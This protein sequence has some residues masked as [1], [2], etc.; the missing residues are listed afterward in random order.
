MGVQKSRMSWYWGS[1]LVFILLILILILVVQ[2]QKY[3]K[4]RASFNQRAC[5]CANAEDVLVN[6]KCYSTH[7]G[8]N[9]TRQVAGSTG[10]G[11]E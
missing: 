3:T 6:C 2:M 7:S 8:I 1:S 4:Q 11:A 10:A 5:S 9:T